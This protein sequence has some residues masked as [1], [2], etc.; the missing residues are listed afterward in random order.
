MK[1]IDRIGG[2]IC[3][4][5]IGVIVTIIIRLSFDMGL[6]ILPI[7]GLI[8]DLLLGTVVGGVVGAI[9][10]KPFMWVVSFFPEVGDN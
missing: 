6:T 8:G 3:G 4:L 7:S 9:F 2:F 1:V 5:V 10:P